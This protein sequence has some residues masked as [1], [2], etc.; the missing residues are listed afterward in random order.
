MEVDTTV[1]ISP[2][3]MGGS[4]EEAEGT[5]AFEMSLAPF[6]PRSLFCTEHP[7]RSNSETLPQCT[8]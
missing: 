7:P 2:F 4:G 3:C 8:S 5:E 6:P 1:S